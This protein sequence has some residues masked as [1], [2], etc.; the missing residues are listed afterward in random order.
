[1]FRINHC[2]MILLAV[3]ALA[4]CSTAYKATP[5]P[6]KAP[7]TLANAVTINGVTMAALAFDDP[8]AARKAFGFDVIGAGLLPIQIIFDHQGQFALEINPEQTFLEDVEG[9]LWPILS[10]RL[11]YDRATRYAHTGQVASDSLQSGLLGAVA[12]SVIGAAVGIV[13]GRGIGEAIGKGAAIGGAAGATIGGAESYDDDRARRAII[14]DLNEKTMKNTP[15]Q[16]GMIAQGFLF[17]PAESAKARQ[18]RLQIAEHGGPVRV[19]QFA[20]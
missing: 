6:F 10:R 4:G 18:L 3:M 15:V 11:A 7:E 16:P 12:G 8:Q 17:F 14:T 1:M 5:L 9:N 2:I 19:V 13:T 20:F